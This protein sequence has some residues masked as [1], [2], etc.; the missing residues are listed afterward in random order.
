VPE[1]DPADGEARL[2]RSGAKRAAL[3]VARPLVD[4]FDRCFQ[5]L[6][7]HLDRLQVGSELRGR[8][9]QVVS[10]TSETREEVA[11]DADVIAELAFT[12]E[13]FA[14]LFTARMEETVEK[15]TWAHT[16]A[17][18]LGSQIVE[19]PFAYGAASRLPVG[20]QV[21]IIDPIDTRLPLTLASLGLHVTVVGAHEPAVGHPNV[22]TVGEPVDRWDGPG[23][24]LDAIFAVSAIGALGLYG[25]ASTPD[26]DRQV[27]ELFRKWLS[28]SGV[29]VLTVPFGTW[30]PG[31]PSR[32]YDD[33]HLEEL[34]ADWDVHERRV[35]E[36]V[37]DRMWSAFDPSDAGRSAPTGVALVRAV[38]RS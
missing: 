1:V 26:L 22:V 13:R 15:L 19:L 7:D 14:D 4:Y 28:D 36:R 23:Q 34:L 18:G 21:A 38:A 11:A 5:D 30:S 6:H 31:P 12:L 29:L 37:D 10:M 3:S 8:L 35:I 17:E 20:A 33:R 9:D 2:P 25:D 16:A 27:L 32:V 24:P